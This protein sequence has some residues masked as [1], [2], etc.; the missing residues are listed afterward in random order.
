MKKNYI[1]E[2][3]GLMLLCLVFF[4]CESTVTTTNLN[5]RYMGSS[6]SVMVIDSCEYIYINNDVRSLTHKGNCKFCFERNEK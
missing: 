1:K 4:G 2:V 6:I 3:I 5:D